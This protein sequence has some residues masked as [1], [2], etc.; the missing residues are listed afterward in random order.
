MF[1]RSATALRNDYDGMV[2]LAKEKNEPIFLTR[3]GDGEMVFLPIEMWEQREAELDMLHTLLK[4]EQ[5]RQAG[6]KTFSMDEMKA[7]TEDAL[8][9]D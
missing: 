2:R 4:R 1:I 8:R 7:M 9:E 5:N 3:N 6:A